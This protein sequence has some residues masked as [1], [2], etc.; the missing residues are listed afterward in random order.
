PLLLDRA[1]L[2][3]MVASGEFD[4]VGVPAESAISAPLLAEGRQLGL[5]AVQSYTVDHVYD[6]GDLD[7]LT[8]VGQHIGSALSRARAIEETR[9]RN[10]ELAV[11]N[12]I[13]E[14]LARQLDFDAIVQLVGERVREIFSARG[15]FIALY[16]PATATL[17]FPY[18]LDEGEPF[19]RG[20]MPFGPGV[21]SEVIRTGKPLRLSTLEDQIAAGAVAVGGTDTQSWLGV[22]IKAGEQVIG[23]VGLESI[24]AYAYSEA[25]ERLL[26][27]L[28]SSMGV[29]LENARLFGETKRLLAEAD[30]R[31]AEL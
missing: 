31:A 23:V 19:N 29:A 26:S 6:R 11:I 3:A 9:E 10:A 1:R 20:V 5:L 8:F 18:D 7:L 22:P 15:I 4:L 25:D 14:A 27:T 24:E 17:T 30:E 12:E 21:T 13:G 2:E 16:H 28:A